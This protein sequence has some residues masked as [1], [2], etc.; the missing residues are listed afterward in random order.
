MQEAN[1]GCMS[2]QKVDFFAW[3]NKGMNGQCS[4]LHGER[5]ARS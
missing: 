2:V 4:T 1:E 5:S 3:E